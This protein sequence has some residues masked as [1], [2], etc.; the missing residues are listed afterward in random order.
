[1]TCILLSVSCGYIREALSVL[2]RWSEDTV[3][4]FANEY[5][6]LRTYR[7]TPREFLLDQVTFCCPIFQRVHLRLNLWVVFLWCSN[8][9]VHSQYKYRKR[10]VCHVLVQLKQS[11]RRMCQFSQNSLYHFR[12]LFLVNCLPQLLQ[13]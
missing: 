2:E 11:L 5:I 9:D 13:H 4:M 1:M 8:L 3:S 6:L 10:V 12:T 7:S